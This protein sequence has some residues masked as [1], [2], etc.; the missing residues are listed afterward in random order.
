MAGGDAR[1]T[2]FGGERRL[3][4]RCHRVMVEQP[5]A[6]VLHIN[7]TQVRRRCHQEIPP[8][9]PLSKGGIGPHTLTRSPRGE[10]KYD[11]RGGDME[12][13]HLGPP[14]RGGTAPL[15]R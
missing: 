3:E 15:P 6:V 5:G 9:P 8:N 10:R 14:L 1:P 11:S 13:G 7:G 2:F 12:G 4:S